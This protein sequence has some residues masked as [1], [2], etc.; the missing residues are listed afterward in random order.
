MEQKINFEELTIQDLKEA[1]FFEA[2][3]PIDKVGW[4]WELAWENRRTTH[5]MEHD[6]E[7]R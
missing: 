1:F 6:E 5:W 3:I 7:G 2:W 4:V